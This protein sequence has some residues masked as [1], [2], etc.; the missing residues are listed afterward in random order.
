VKKKNILTPTLPLRRGGRG[1]HGCDKNA[2]GIRE[3]CIVL[4]GKGIRFRALTG[5]R[6]FSRN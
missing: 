5:Q 3:K 6:V 4:K 2:I 1:R